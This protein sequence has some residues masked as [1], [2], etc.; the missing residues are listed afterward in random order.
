MAANAS[1]KINRDGSIAANKASKARIISCL[2]ILV[3]ALI[4]LILLHLNS[5]IF[6]L[7]TWL[8]CVFIALLSVGSGTYTAV[9]N[10]VKMKG[11]F[12]W[13][14]IFFWAG[15]LASI[16]IDGLMLRHGSATTTQA[17]LFALVLLALTLYL[18]GVTS[19]IPLALVGLTV[20]LMVIGSLVI[21]NYLLL[22]I[23]PLVIIMGCAV[24]L[25]I[26]RNRSSLPAGE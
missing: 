14:L 9:L 24:F 6:W 7:Y 17:G 25:M 10:K 3:L 22:V 19:D 26:K 4:S 11:P 23:T 13:R 16:Y 21:K 18:I 1:V 2:I 15:F 12:F 8:M 5:S 20:A